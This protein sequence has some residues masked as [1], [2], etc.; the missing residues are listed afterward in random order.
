MQILFVDMC[1]SWRNI[2]RTTCV[3]ICYVMYDRN[4]REIEIFTKH[5]AS[6]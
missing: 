3:E 6:S 4:E 2:V 5:T 1:C